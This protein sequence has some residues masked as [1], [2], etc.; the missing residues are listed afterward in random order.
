VSWWRGQLDAVNRYLVDVRQQL[1]VDQ[2]FGMVDDVLETLIVTRKAGQTQRI[3]RVR[4]SGP[5]PQFILSKT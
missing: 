3:V 4:S 5:H 1:V 2:H